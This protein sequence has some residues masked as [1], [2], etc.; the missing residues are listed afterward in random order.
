M[1]KVGVTT[2]ATWI[3]EVVNL[4]LRALSVSLAQCLKLN[5]ANLELFSMGIKL[6]TCSFISTGELY[7]RAEYFKE[8]EADLDEVLAWM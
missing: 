4:R 7:L 1:K 3:T 6:Y 2:P 8:K 5:Q